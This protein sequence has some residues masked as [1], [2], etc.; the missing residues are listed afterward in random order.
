MALAVTVTV[1]RWTVL[2]G[3]GLLGVGRADV[4]LAGNAVAVVEGRSLAQAAPNSAR[5]NTEIAINFVVTI[6]R[7]SRGSPT[8][9][10]R[11]EHAV[12]TSRLGTQ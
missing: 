7:I 10:C 5:D 8:S 12:R 9:A 3:V 2:E 1:T 4:G 6:P 11:R